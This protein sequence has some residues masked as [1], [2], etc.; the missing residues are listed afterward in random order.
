MSQL[1][2]NNAKGTL[3]T[4]IGSGSLSAVLN[5]GQGALFPVLSGADYFLATLI[6]PVSGTETSWE[7]VKVTARSTDTLTLTRAQEGTTAA[8]WPL[9][10]PIEVRWTA[11]MAQLAANPVAPA[12][13]TNLTSQLFGG[14]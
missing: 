9:N 11:G 4:A 1:F 5:A 2:T 3:S 6:A 7:V 12:S 8:A 13:L 10:T 14:L